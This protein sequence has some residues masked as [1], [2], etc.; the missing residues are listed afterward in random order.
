RGLH[1]FPTRRSS[2]LC[3]GAEA[4]GTGDGFDWRAS[5]GD[6]EGKEER[7][8]KANEKQVAGNHYRSKIQHWDLVRTT[9]MGYFE[10]Q[11]TKYVSRDRKSTRLNSSH[12]K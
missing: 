12:V 5:G 10:G 3:S 11:I 7:G 6:E 2:D 9:G 4:P 8:M 1:S